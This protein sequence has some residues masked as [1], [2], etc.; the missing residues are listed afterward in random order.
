MALKNVLLYVYVIILYNGDYDYD[1]SIAW[2][3]K[4]DFM[5]LVSRCQAIDLNADGFTWI[6]SCPWEWKSFI[7]WK[8]SAEILLAETFWRGIFLKKMEVAS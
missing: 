1:I 6:C 7:A 2:L 4:G 8:F 5:Y 3:N